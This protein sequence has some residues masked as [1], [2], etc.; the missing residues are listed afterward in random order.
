MSEAMMIV[1]AILAVS[2]IIAIIRE[3]FSMM[4]RGLI[5]GVGKVIHGIGFAAIW[6]VTSVIKIIIV[7]FCVLWGFIRE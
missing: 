6:I 3:L 4:A 5:R 7:P 2:F 1:G